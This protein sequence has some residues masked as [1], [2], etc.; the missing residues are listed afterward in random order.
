MVNV[1]IWSDIAD[2]QVLEGDCLEKMKPL[3]SNSIDAI[4][5]DP[6]YGIGF[7]G[8]KWDASVPALDWALDC[9]RVLKP[10]GHI[11]AFA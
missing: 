4:I 8:K 1:N 6:P 5:T 11:V 3:P 10:G 7:M 2:A 9:V